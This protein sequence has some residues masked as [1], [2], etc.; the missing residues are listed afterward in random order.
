MDVILDV[1]DVEDGYRR[2]VIFEVLRDGLDR[3][4]YREVSH[5]RHDQVLLLHLTKVDRLRRLPVRGSAEAFVGAGLLVGEQIDELALLLLR[6]PERSAGQ[7]WLV[8]FSDQIDG[9]Q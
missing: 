4:D 2:A 7:E 1:G 8:A 6:E 3:L 9:K 5:E